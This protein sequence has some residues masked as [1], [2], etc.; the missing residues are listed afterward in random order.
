MLFNIYSGKREKRNPTCALLCIL[1]P[2]STRA[3]LSLPSEVQG[4][5]LK[6]HVPL[7]SAH[8]RQAE[9]TPSENTPCP[10]TLGWSLHAESN[11][12]VAS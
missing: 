2:I 7:K 1:L 6:N 11:F 4:L 3:N 12:M 9:V 5:C 10:L 8:T